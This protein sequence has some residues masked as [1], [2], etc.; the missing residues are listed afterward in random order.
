MLSETNQTEKDRYHMISL[1]CGI[2]NSQTHKSGEQSGDC[3]GL[4]VGG[5]GE[6]LVKGYKISVRGWTSS[7]DLM[8]SNLITDNKTV[9]YI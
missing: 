6:T 7:G 4:R 9:L 2:Q 5:N 3:Q 1:T 8:Y